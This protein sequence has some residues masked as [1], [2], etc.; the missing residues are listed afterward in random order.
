M[1]P[2]NRRC[3]PHPRLF[4]RVRIQRLKELPFAIRLGARSWQIYAVKIRRFVH[5]ACRTAASFFCLFGRRECDWRSARCVPARVRTVYAH[6]VAHLMAH[7][8]R[9]SDASALGQVCVVFA[10]RNHGSIH[11]IP[12]GVGLLPHKPFAQTVLS[13]ARI[14]GTHLGPVR[15]ARRCAPW[16]CAWPRA[17]SLS[18]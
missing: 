13:V 12:F 8:A 16:P 14:V 18:L 2:R 17:V 1:Q 9:W 7:F 6:H 10:V 4:Q 15:S 5:A 3:E 11:R